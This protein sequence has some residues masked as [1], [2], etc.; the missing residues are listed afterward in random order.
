M[1]F[2]R[3]KRSFTEHSISSDHSSANDRFDLKLQ[4]LVFAQQN[5]SLFS[6]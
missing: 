1:W 5:F 4:E 3:L 6:V 2:R